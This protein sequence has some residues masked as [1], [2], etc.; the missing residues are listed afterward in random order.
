MHLCA[1]SGKR[2]SC[3]RELYVSWHWCRRVLWRVFAPSLFN[4]KIGAVAISRATRKGG[5]GGG[6]KRG[7]EKE[8]KSELLSTVSFFPQIVVLFCTFLNDPKCCETVRR[9]AQLHYYFS[10]FYNL[11]DFLKIQVA[12]LPHSAVS[13][14]LCLP[15]QTWA[16]DDQ[17]QKRPCLVTGVGIVV[18]RVKTHLKRFKKPEQ[19]HFKLYVTVGELAQSSDSAQPTR[20]EDGLLCSPYLCLYSTFLLQLI[21]HRCLAEENIFCPSGGRDRKIPASPPG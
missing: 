18:S 20:D 3:H 9:L 4:K 6:N 16:R 11:L 13:A 12:F 5:E 2:F 21:T 1:K 14:A 7:S 10:S 8:R 17:P 15:E 19:L